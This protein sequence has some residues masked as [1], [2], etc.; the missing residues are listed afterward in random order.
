MQNDIAQFI[1]I[2]LDLSQQRLGDEYYYPSIS[3]CVVDAIFS[4]GVRY[5]STRATVKRFS[6]YFSIPLLRDTTDLPEHD[7]FPISSLLA[8]Y[9]KFGADYFAKSI[10][11]N[12]Q[13]TSAKN[14]IL[15][16]EAVRDYSAV[17]AR[18]GLESIADVESVIGDKSF[19]AEVRNIKGQGSGISTDY[20]YM[21][22]GSDNHIKA[23]RRIISFVGRAHGC[24]IGATEA[25]A[26]LLEGFNELKEQYPHLTLRLLDY[27]IWSYEKEK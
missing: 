17:L 25:R 4:I 26:L 9:E 13:R 15:K 2:T 3:Q 27:L 18:H 16:A 22:S 7:P 24:S 1:Q 12:R 8:E 19:E 21:L 23:D 10:F 11:V 14:G 6:S 20:F 5:V